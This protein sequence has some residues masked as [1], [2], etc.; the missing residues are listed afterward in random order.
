MN[1]DKAQKLLKMC[2]GCN[3]KTLADFNNFKLATDSNE[4]LAKAVIQ[5]YIICKSE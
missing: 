2:K 4:T 5:N 3:I 1:I